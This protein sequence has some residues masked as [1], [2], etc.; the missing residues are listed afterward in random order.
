MDQ[1]NIN[2]PKS[3]FDVSADTPN[4]ETQQAIEDV[5]AGR[6]LSK[7]FHTISDLIDDLNH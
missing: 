7:T 4:A 6:N 3:Q 1:T 5:D 2:I